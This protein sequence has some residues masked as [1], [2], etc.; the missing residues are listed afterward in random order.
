M[1]ED[2]A[3]SCPGAVIAVPTE[4]DEPSMV[5]VIVPVLVMAVAVLALIAAAIVAAAILRRRRRRYTLWS[6]NTF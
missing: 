2:N 6:C 3:G 1:E 5:D 4:A